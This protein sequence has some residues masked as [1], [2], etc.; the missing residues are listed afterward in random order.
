MSHKADFCSGTSTRFCLKFDLHAQGDPLTLVQVMA[1]VQ[2]PR[3]TIGGVNLV[4]GFRQSLGIGMLSL[5]TGHFFVFGDMQRIQRSC[6]CSIG[7]S[8][9]PVCASSRKSCEKSSA[10][11]TTRSR[12]A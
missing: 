1:N 5:V 8:N 9:R 11:N 6:I 10:S 3:M 2:E 12:S 7:R 4:V